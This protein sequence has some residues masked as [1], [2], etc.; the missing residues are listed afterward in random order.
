MNLSACHEHMSESA[1]SAEDVSN[2]P[3]LCYV[4]REAG[5]SAQEF[6]AGAQRHLIVVSTSNGVLH[7]ETGGRHAS[8][9]VEPGFVTVVPKGQPVRWWWD[10]PMSYAVLALDDAFLTELADTGQGRG[11]GSLALRFSERRQDPAIASI[12]KLMGELGPH[13]AAADT[14]YTDAVARVLAT[15]LL[16]NYAAPQDASDPS[17]PRFRSRAVAR[18]AN[19]MEQHYTADL[20]LDDIARAAFLSP[21]HLSRLFKRETGLAP[22]QYLVRVRLEA[23]RARMTETPGGSLSEIAMAVG[24]CDQSHMT[25][26]FRRAFGMTPGQMDPTRKMQRRLTLVHSAREPTPAP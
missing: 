21:F 2:A 18:A 26:Q 8:H 24:F 4:H 15:H 11:T 1:R 10:D 9:R 14:A 23:A 20:K 13:D 3:A 7:R 12:A 16:G 5:P 19:F 6:P 25:R 17:Q 22:H